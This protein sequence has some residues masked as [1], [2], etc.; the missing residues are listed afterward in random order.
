MRA[1]TEHRLSFTSGLMPFSSSICFMATSRRASA[2]HSVNQ[3]MV[4]Q[5][6]RPGNIRQ[7]SRKPSPIGDMHSTMCRFLMT[8]DKK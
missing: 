5:L 3:S 6:T 4:Q 8:R 2:G 7:R 1:N